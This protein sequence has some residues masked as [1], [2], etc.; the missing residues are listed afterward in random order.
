MIVDKDKL[1]DRAV[2][3]FNTIN[4]KEELLPG[5]TDTLLLAT[6]VISYMENVDIAEM[7]EYDKKEYRRKV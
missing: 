4:T 3:A 2:R 1:L 7:F 5:D 6:A